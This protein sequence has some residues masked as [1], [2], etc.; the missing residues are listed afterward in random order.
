MSLTNPALLPDPSIPGRQADR[1]LKVVRAKALTTYFLPVVGVAG[2]AVG[3]SGRSSPLL[4]LFTSVFAAVLAFALSTLSYRANCT[5]EI[6]VGP[7][8]VVIR[9]DTRRAEL[10]TWSRMTAPARGLFSYLWGMYEFGL[11]TGPY[12]TSVCYLTMGQLRAIL[13]YQGRPKWDLAD[14]VYLWAGL[15]PQ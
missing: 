3:F 8:G 2:G 13:A 15:S 14:S 11:M 7:D 4:L 10:W 9:P 12:V 5:S 1:A 6:Q